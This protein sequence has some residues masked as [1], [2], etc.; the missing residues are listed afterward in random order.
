MTIPV[1]CFRE[2]PMSNA[3]YEKRRAELVALV[4]EEMV[5]QWEKDIDE[6][7]IYGARP[8]TRPD[9]AGILNP[10]VLKSIFE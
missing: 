3:L 6:Y 1:P 4:G 7:M 2:I 8:T 9:P 10:P 5:I